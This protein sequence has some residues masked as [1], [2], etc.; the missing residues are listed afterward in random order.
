M[1]KIFIVISLT[2]FGSIG[3]S[4]VTIDCKISASLEIIANYDVTNNSILITKRENTKVVSFPGIS[5]EQLSKESLDQNQRLMDLAKAAEIPIE[6]ANSA[7]L[8]V[9]QKSASESTELVD[10]I[11]VE[12][13]SLGT[14]AVLGPVIQKCQ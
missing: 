10:F 8:F 7:N 11:S 5:F 9:V 6:R 3:L 14:L 4:Q 13:E 12:A 1:K 2:N